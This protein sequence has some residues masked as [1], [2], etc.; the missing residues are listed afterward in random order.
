ME[1]DI[2]RIRKTWAAAVGANDIVGTIFY[3][4]L[5]QVAPETRGLF[6]DDIDPQGRKLVLTLSWILDHVEDSSTLI[7]AAEDL[8]RRHVAYGVQADHYPIVG[9]VLINTLK[10][11]LGGD[12]TDEDVGA[13]VRIYSDLSQTMTAAAYPQPT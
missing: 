11:T 5:F 2:R 9:E 12:F 7:P 4:N 1:D 8:A 13:W 10:D 6:P 3:R